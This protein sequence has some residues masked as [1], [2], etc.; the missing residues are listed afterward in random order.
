MESL[1]LR[2]LKGES[3]E[4]A[5]VWL[6][7]QAGRYMAEY[8]EL[9]QEHGF[10][11]LC[12]NPELA[13]EVTLQPIRAFKPDAAIIFADIL[14]PAEGMGFE[15]EFNPGPQVGG[16]VRG[17]DDVSRLKLADPFLATPY[18]LDAL[19]LTSKELA[20]VHPEASLLGFAGTPWTMA[21]YLCDQGPYK[22]FQGTQVFAAQQPKVFQ[23]LL[24]LLTEVTANYLAAQFESGAEA[25][26]L[27]DSWGGNL[28]YEDYKRYSLPSI[29][30]IIETLRP[31]QKPIT[32]YVNGGNHLLPLL[33]SSGADCLS[34]DSRTDLAHAEEALGGLVSLQGNFDPTHLFHSSEE[35]ESETRAMLTSLKNRGAYVANLGHGVL[36]KTP[37][38]NV[39]TFIDT[40]K[41]GW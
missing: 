29:Q 22:H 17:L 13:C 3:T 12:R 18:V 31:Y 24:D 5:P 21:C 40:V 38:E 27:F 14:L 15:I 26:Q 37:P 7:R 32:L 34:I 36:Q 6:M 39:K 28:S 16:K 19:K 10:L 11:G 41:Q 9:K 35:I 20:K 25:V 4:R 23:R 33:A 1:L 2:A 30:K 8:R